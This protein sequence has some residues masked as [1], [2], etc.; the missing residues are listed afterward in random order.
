MQKSEMAEPEEA[1]V[2][3]HVRVPHAQLLHLPNER[4][5]GEGLAAQQNDEI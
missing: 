4:R 2:L 3:A 1:E 5:D